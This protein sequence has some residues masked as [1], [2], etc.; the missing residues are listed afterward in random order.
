MLLPYKGVWPKQIIYWESRAWVSVSFGGAD[1]SAF[2]LMNQ[3]IYSMALAE[4]IRVALF[5]FR[6]QWPHTKSRT[7][8]VLW[9]GLP[10]LENIFG[11]HGGRGLIHAC[12]CISQGLHLSL[13][14]SNTLTGTASVSCWR[15]FHFLNLF[16]FFLNLHNSPFWYV[17]EHIGPGRMHWPWKAKGFF[18]ATFLSLVRRDFFFQH[19][20]ISQAILWQ[21]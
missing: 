3:F 11:C 7:A 8:T 16:F 14:C 13:T 10:R 6:A 18:V 17:Q 2:S 1:S 12:S 20:P 15:H 9:S 5:K 21:G 4:S 19:N